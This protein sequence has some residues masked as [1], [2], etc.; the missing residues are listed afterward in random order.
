MA[1]L[2]APM[3]VVKCDRDG[4]GWATFVC[5]HLF[6]SIDATGDER[7]GFCSDVP[8]PDNPWPDAW[9]FSCDERFV[10]NGEQWTDDD[11]ELLGIKMLCH[12]C[13]ERARTNNDLDGDDWPIFDRPLPEPVV[14]YDVELPEP[15]DSFDEKLL[16]DVREYGWHFI[17]VAD[18]HHPEHAAENAA[19]EPH[20]IYDAAFGYTVGLSLTRAHPELVLV[21]RWPHAHAIVANAVAE[22]DR[23]VRF[24]P[25][26]RNDQILEGY[27]VTF[28]RVS[29]ERRNELLTYASWAN[30]RR[31][32]EALQLVLPDS[33][34]RWP[35]EADYDSVPE[36][37]LD[38]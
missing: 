9:C 26:S 4:R 14:A 16:A 7:V 18:E 13:Y 12:H 1:V 23:G 25:G 11:S 31:P 10:A 35:W 38:P 5:Q 3:E 24:E 19:L 30:Q 29:D 34:G 32:F 28:A 15:E 17:H 33:R 2:C 6:D 37:L 20:P 22:I 27:S 21:G 8:T 36:P